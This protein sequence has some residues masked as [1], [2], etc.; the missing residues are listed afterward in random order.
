MSFFFKI[1]RLILPNA[2]QFS[3]NRSICVMPDMTIPKWPSDNDDDDHV[4]RRRGHDTVPM[5]HG[6]D[7]IC[8]CVCSPS[9]C[10]NDSRDC[11]RRCRDCK[12]SDIS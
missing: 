6:M 7:R 5:T 12:D 9:I 2:A 4:N 1:S 8:C 10:Q 3:R 11:F